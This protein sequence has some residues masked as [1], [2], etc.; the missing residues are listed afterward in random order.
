ML[1]RRV[2]VRHDRVQLDTVHGTYFDIDVGTHPAGSHFNGTAET[3]NLARML[4]FIQQEILM[5]TP[6]SHVW[7]PSCARSI[8]VDSFVPVPRGSTAVA[9]PLLSWPT[10]DPGDTLDYEVDVSPAFAGDDGDSIATLDVT[11]FP[12]NPGDLTVTSITAD[13]PRCVFWLTAGQ[14]G[15]IYTVTIAVGTTNGRT[16]QR[17]VLVPVLYLSVPRAPADALETN[18][19]AVVTDQNGNPILAPLSL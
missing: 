14:N 2:S 7:K 5:P 13:G 16:I 17:S 12:D 9:P 1:L 15:T 3:Q 4:D 11:V 6:A 18:T 10:K 8:T 19:G